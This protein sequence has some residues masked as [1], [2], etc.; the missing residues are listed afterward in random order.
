MCALTFIRLSKSCH[1][2]IKIPVPI[3]NIIYEPRYS[4][5]LAVLSRS[6]RSSPGSLS[7]MK[8]LRF[9]K[10]RLLTATQFWYR[11]ES[12]PR[13]SNSTTNSLSSHF[14]C[15]SEIQ[16]MLALSSKLHYI[17][18]L[19]QFFRYDRNLMA[20]QMGKLVRFYL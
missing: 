10:T 18:F 1:L 6:K 19:S 8:I 5:I 9:L 17:A 11:M 2:N 13:K 16:E 12:F 7:L 14:S 20:S 3:N 15:S 4:F